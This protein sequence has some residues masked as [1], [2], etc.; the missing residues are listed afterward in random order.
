MHAVMALAHAVA[1]AD[2]AE[3]NGGA[4]GTI[5]AVLDPLGHLAKVEVTGNTLTPGI[6]NADNGAFE[7]IR[8]KAHGLECCAVVLISQSFQ[9]MFT[10]FHKNQA[11]FLLLFS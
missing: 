4:A 9:D 2:D 7:V 11:P 10:A 1:S 6:G 5:D 3:F 8:G